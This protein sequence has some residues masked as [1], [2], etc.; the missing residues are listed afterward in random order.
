MTDMSEFKPLHTT[1]SEASEGDCGCLC[2][3]GEWRLGRVGHSDNPK[4]EMLYVD[5]LLG[6]KAEWYEIEALA[7][8]PWMPISAPPYDG[9][10]KPCT[11]AVTI[12]DRRGTCII[13]W[14][15][16]ETDG[17]KSVQRVSDYIHA[18]LQEN[19]A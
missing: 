3:D 12:Q 10:E 17:K 13:S 14:S 11:H 7:S 6:E 18:M 1:L 4:D 15:M 19:P 5:L 16:N 2:Y 8:L 9:D